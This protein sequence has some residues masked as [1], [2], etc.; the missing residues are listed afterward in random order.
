MVWELKDCGLK[1]N[2]LFYGVLR[3][4]RLIDFLNRGLEMDDLTDL[5]RDLQG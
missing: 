5:R 3:R 4:A 1:K 2:Y